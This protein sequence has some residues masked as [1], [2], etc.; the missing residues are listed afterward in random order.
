[1]TNLCVD[2]V[3]DP[4]RLIPV[5]GTSNTLLWMYIIE[6]KVIVPVVLAL[7]FLNHSSMVFIVPQFSSD[8][9]LKKGMRNED[10]M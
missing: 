2:V 4:I 10:C 3:A 7:H 9:L 8:T 1:M 5:E 6:E